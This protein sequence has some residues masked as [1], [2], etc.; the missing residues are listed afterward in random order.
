[1]TTCR[2]N[3]CLLMP[4]V[5]LLALPSAH[6]LCACNAMHVCFHG[7]GSNSQAHEQ[8][9]RLMWE[10]EEASRLN[11]EAQSEI[12]SE[13]A[14]TVEDMAGPTLGGCQLFAV[15]ACCHCCYLLRPLLLAVAAAGN[16]AALL[17]CC[18]HD[19]V[20]DYNLLYNCCMMYPGLVIS[21]PNT[22]LLL[23][24]LHCCCVCLS[25]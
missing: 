7:A 6:S 13:G 24:G 20:V 19:H 14:M 23:H 4:P 15:A 3:M 1:M 11:A 2:V 9:E 17:F 8:I 18:T 22:Q 21:V 16:T 5:L 12:V 10:L 25:P